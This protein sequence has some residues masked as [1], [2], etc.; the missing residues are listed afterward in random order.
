MQM[1]WTFILQLR[2]AKKCQRESCLEHEKDSI[3]FKYRDAV[4]KALIYAIGLQ[5]D[6][7]MDYT[8]F[9]ILNNTIYRI[10]FPLYVKNL[11]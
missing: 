2:N 6:N 8:F 4:N 11:F 10:K 5:G 9:A 1:S 7:F 3:R